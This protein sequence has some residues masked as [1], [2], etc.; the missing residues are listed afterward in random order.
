MGEAQ[1]RQGGGEGGEGGW[2]GGWRSLLLVL[3]T[4]LGAALLGVEVGQRVHRSLDALLLLEIFLISVM[5]ER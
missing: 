3:P 1:L 4:L 2:Q 5:F